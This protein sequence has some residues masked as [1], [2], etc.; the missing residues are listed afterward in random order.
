MHLISPRAARDAALM[1]RA[2]KERTENTQQNK[3]ETPVP[4][5][6]T[7]DCMHALGIRGLP[8][9]RLGALLAVLPSACQPHVEARVEARGSDCASCHLDE[10]AAT[11]N[12]PHVGDTF[13]ETC[14][15]CH[16]QQSWSPAEGYVHT[17]AFPL[18]DKHAT[19]ACVSCHLGDYNPETV[20]SACVDCHGAQADAV[21]SP[22]HSGL[23]TVCEA[24]HEP[25][26][27]APSTFEHSWP[28]EGVHGTLPCVVCHAGD[29]PEYFG[30]SS[31]CTECHADD[32]ERANMNVP[33]HD[34]FGTDCEGC[35]NFDA[36][37]A[38]RP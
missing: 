12:P 35:H 32:L 33:G 21:P 10:Y 9:A 36:F 37:R 18:T 27:F 25:S 38:P 17:E 7:P 11:L 19:T 14:G 31:E 23:S 30:K 34:T 2:N 20:R 3:V 29:P 4:A 13:N 22:I 28:L 6:Y 8:L 16:E 26:G 15:T 1:G 5:I 24:C